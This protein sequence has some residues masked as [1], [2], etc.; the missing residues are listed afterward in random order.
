MCEIHGIWLIW[1]AGDSLS[2]CVCLLQLKTM[3]FSPSPSSSFLL[4]EQRG[5]EHINQVFFG[6]ERWSCVPRMK[7][8]TLRWGGRRGKG[9]IRRN[10]PTWRRGAVSW[11]IFYNRVLEAMQ[12]HFP[13]KS[14]LWFGSSH[15]HFSAHLK[16]TPPILRIKVCFHVLRSELTIVSAAP[17]MQQLMGS[18]WELAG[19]P[20]VNGSWL[21]SSF[22]GRSP[23]TSHWDDRMTPAF[24]FTFSI[25][26]IG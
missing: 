3:L 17:S 18:L 1:E 25:K 8:K 20:S 7:E 2:P 16:G 26:W 14:F 9:R 15:L 24:T 5:L 23:A 22:Q 11:N 10:L 6:S 12:T 13:S 4:P 19:A 21:T